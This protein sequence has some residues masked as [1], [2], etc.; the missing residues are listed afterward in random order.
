MN[1]LSTLFLGAILCCA[2]GVNAKSTDKEVRGDD[3][4][5]RYTGRT[6]VSDDG[7]VTFDWV[8]TYFETKLTGG[9]L[10]VKLSETGT[11]YYNVFVDNKLHRV[12]K[13][14]GKDTV[15]DFVSGIGRNAHSAY[16]ETHGR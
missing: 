14:C 6:Q 16:T 5:V 2:H 4:A 1:K 7:S 9:K 3:A 15:I 10:A 11:S 8:G 13:A 12:V